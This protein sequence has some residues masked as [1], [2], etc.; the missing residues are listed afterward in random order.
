MIVFAVAIGVEQRDAIENQV[1]KAVPE[2][3]GFGVKDINPEFIISI[4][5]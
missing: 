1:V 5:C 3:L 4:W 2:A